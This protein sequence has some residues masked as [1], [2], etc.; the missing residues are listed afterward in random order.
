MAGTYTAVVDDFAVGGSGTTQYDYSDVYALPNLGSI[1][2]NDTAAAH[3]GGL[4]VVGGRDGEASGLAGHRAVPPGLR[5]GH[6]ACGAVVGRAEVDLERPLGR[7]QAES[8]IGEAART[9]PG[10]RLARF[11][12]SLR[13]CG[14][15]RISV[16]SGLWR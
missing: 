8:T 10:G 6:L 13:A 15:P 3:A 2:T 7:T 12:A 16:S 1:T 9:R 5:A 4:D 14:S 11:G